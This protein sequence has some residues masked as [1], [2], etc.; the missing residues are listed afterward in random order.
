MKRNLFLF[1]IVSIFLIP[2][3]ANA[4]TKTVLGKN[5]ETKNFIEALEDEE[6]EKQFSNYE[7][8]SDKI[9]I[10]LFRGKGCA[11]CRSYLN[12]MNG[13][14]DE[15][16]KYFNI[17]SF[18]VWYNEDNWNLMRQVSYYLEEEVAGGVPYIIIGDKVFPGFAESFAD[19]IKKAI[20][21]LYNTNVNERYD[22]FK[23]AEKNGLISIDELNKLSNSGNDENN[24]DTDGDNNTYVATS[25]N[26]AEMK[27]SDSINIILWNL[28]F[29]SASTVIILLFNNYKF[30]KL[31]NELSSNT[32]TTE[33]KKKKS[34]R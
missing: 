31:K 32:N 34:V 6:L 15:Y 14:T 12:Y 27:K 29:V 11:F 4:G 1:I 19:D 17:V 23:E 30:N 7:E 28:L 13:I 33:R 21:D 5:Y 18:E 22:V 8:S 3:C 9:N 25:D 2:F 24:T 10:Y 20:V 26:S 16:G